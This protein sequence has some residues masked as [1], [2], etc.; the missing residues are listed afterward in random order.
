MVSRKS[1]NVTFIHTVYSLSCCM[2]SKLIFGKQEVYMSFLAWWWFLTSSLY[3]CRLWLYSKY[4]IALLALS[5]R[6]VRKRF[7][8]HVRA[9][10]HSCVSSNGTVILY[11][12]YDH[13]DAGVY[14][15]ANIKPVWNSK[16][17]KLRLMYDIMFLCSDSHSE[18]MQ[19]SLTS[20]FV[21]C[22]VPKLWPCEVTM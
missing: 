9:C 13:H 2:Q 3:D 12:W 1:F 6:F 18:N 8:C 7:R 21:E 5:P 11:I 4:V 19:I 14:R 17:R 22:N 16:R 15:K 20:L 10:A